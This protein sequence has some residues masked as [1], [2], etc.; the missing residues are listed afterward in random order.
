M[1]GR[2]RRLVRT[3]LPVL[4]LAALL[5]ACD[6]LLVP[7]PRATSPAAIFDQ[8]WGDFDRY[9]AHFE[10]SGVDWQAARARYRPQAVAA[11]NEYVLSSV[12][13]GMLAELE[14]PHVTLYTPVFT[15]QDTSSYR[16]GCFE[17]RV[18]ERYV[19]T[20]S[21][22]GG[23]IAYG[24]IDAHTGYIRIPSFAGT[25]WS[26]EI[27][28]ALA[29]LADVDALVLDVRANGGG[30]PGTAMDI[31]G[32]FLQKSG[33]AEYIRYRSGP[34]H[35]D[36]GQAYAIEAAP[37]GPRR[38]A[39]RVA[40]LTDRRDFSAAE[41]FVLDLRA[42]ARLTVV[43][44]TTGGASGRPIVRELPNGWT[45]RLSTWVA[46]TPAGQSYEKIGLPP[47]VAVRPLPGDWSHGIDRV[48]E[49]G[50]AALR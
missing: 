32:R 16:P 1:S 23:H 12:L 6:R 30:D 20:S 9:Y 47:D 2:A 31:A 18:T 17:P 14:D 3:L 40:L 33:V 19:A 15:Y 11:A 8:V 39:G 37:A 29:A 46:Y 49:A 48:L 4:A 50:I 10:L 24:R 13:A 38:F 41:S 35:D 28:D 36:F 27:D 34:A 43:G 7:D 45:Y 5:A 44:D 22:A 21:T 25:G 42:G 26:G